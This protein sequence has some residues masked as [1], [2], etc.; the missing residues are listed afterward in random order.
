MTPRRL[1]RWRLEQSTPIEPP[2]HP[3]IRIGGWLPRTSDADFLRTQL[4]LAARARWD[5]AVI[6]PPRYGPFPRLKT[7][8]LPLLVD[9][10]WQSWPGK[11]ACLSYPALVALLLSGQ[12]TLRPLRYRP[13]PRWW[14][15]HPREGHVLR[16]EQLADG[17]L[18]RRLRALQLPPW[19]DTIPQ[20]LLDSLTAPQLPQPFYWLVEQGDFTMLTVERLLRLRAA[21]DVSRLAEPMVQTQGEQVARVRT[22]GSQGSDVSAP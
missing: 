5:V 7:S 16:P 8:P 22:S 15:H 20:A 4:D 17:R 14:L 9:T 21:S 2:R 10:T 3:L 18:P 19:L 1:R 12:H 11:E 13:F 6:T